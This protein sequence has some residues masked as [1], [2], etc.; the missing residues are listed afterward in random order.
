[1]T[2]KTL[3]F[4]ALTLGILTGLAGHAFAQGAAAQDVYFYPAKSWATGMAPQGGICGI[5]TEF[6]N[7]FVVQINGSQ[8]KPFALNIDFRQ[9]IFEPGKT[10][11]VTVGVPGAQ[12]Q[13]FSTKATGPNSMGLDLSK[14][15]FG[16]MRDASVFDVGV[17]GNSFRFYLT[18]FAAA[19]GSFQQ[20]LQDAAA[21]AV[22]EAD[23]QAPVNEASALEKKEAQKIAISEIAPVDPKPAMQVIPY[24]P[25]KQAAPELT[26]EE[27]RAL[28]GPQTGRKRMSE[29]LAEQIEQNPEIAGL[30]QGTADAVVLPGQPI[31]EKKV[32]SA[33]EP[34]PMSA[35]A[36]EKPADAPV[37]PSAK[38]PAIPVEPADKT[39]AEE[40]VAVKSAAPDDMSEPV[41]IPEP[42]AAPAPDAK[43]LVAKITEEKDAVKA[44]PLK[45]A[46]AATPKEEIKF[47][48]PR[49]EP[50]P[51]KP[52][53]SLN[54]VAGGA[55]NAPI[56]LTA[57]PQG[58]DAAKTSKVVSSPEMVVR[59]DVRSGNVDFTDVRIE[60]DVPFSTPADSAR[61]ADPDML[62]KITELE[63]MIRDL[64]RENV[65]LNGELKSSLDEARGE[66]ISI[67]SDNWDLER[68]TM[69]YNEAQR[70]IKRLGQQL[71]QERA[72]RNVEKED[73]E[74]QLFDPQVTSQQ[75]IARLADLERKLAASEEKLMDQR[76]RYEERI[77]MLEQQ[78]ATQ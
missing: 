44:E 34:T 50:A 27:A 17:E 66:K 68:A 65:A 40:T 54:A 41:F 2:F 20:C 69:R 25:P 23:G 15:T 29:Q 58:A 24:T 22:P 28:Q 33:K 75:Q 37:S 73:L 46:N 72:Q 63:E 51:V 61:K 32:V 10:Y 52:P 19:L 1:M 64:K 35:P 42:A 36:K 18:G 62:R 21:H 3:K 38:S 45:T 7:G 11:N 76:L 47:N 8:D 4:S 57:P 53:A 55:A 6:N 56:D 48:S 9:D 39:P 74:A 30:K 60:N 16:A 77:K 70:E 5:G 59:K 71:Q 13:S 43:A 67:S 14:A 78:R 49:V 31:L 12:A 26:M